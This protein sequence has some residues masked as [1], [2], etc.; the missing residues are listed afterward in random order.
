MPG[1]I[2]VSL[3]GD[4]ELIAMLERLGERAPKA[5]GRGLYRAGHRIMTSSQGLVP[6]GGPPTSPRDPHP[7]ALKGSGHVSEPLRDGTGYRVELGYGG[8]AAA[9]AYRQHREKSW[10]HKPGQQA[11]YLGKPVR[12]SGDMVLGEVAREIR[13]EFGRL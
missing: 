2:I 5:A 1:R 9:Y 10:R 3:R 11:D 8:A 12:E 4:R 13:E 6:V 7:G